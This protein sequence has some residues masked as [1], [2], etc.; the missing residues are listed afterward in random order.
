VITSPTKI[1]T[2]KIASDF[3]VPSRSMITPQI[4]VVTMFG[5]L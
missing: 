3:R 5:K 4:S 2:P 1:S